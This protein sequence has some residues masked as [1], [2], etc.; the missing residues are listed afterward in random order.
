MTL[1]L[2][3]NHSFIVSN[4]G[5]I[6]F[7]LGLLGRIIDKVSEIFDTV[8]DSSMNT[9]YQNKLLKM[10]YLVLYTFKKPPHSPQHSLNMA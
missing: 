4:E 3:H 7:L 1:S 5:K 8:I 10:K 2:L 6:I 9:E